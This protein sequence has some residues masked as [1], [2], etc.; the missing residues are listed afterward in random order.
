LFGQEG[1]KLGGAFYTVVW[2]RDVLVAVSVA[3][4]VGATVF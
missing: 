4:S 1:T 3:P 2:R